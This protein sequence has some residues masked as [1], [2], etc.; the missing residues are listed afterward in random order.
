MA[1]YRC[2]VCGYLF[3]EEKEG[4]SFAELKE[5]PVCHSRNTDYLTRVIGYLKRVSNFSKPRQKEAAARHYNH[6][7][8]E[9]ETAPAAVIETT[10]TSC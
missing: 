2:S 10:P 1:I 8:A 9:T 6:A 7:A 3:D 4:K 5:C